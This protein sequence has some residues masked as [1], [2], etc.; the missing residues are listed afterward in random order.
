LLLQ[1]LRVQARGLPLLRNLPVLGKLFGSEDYLNERSELVAILL[2]ASAPPP[3]PFDRLSGR[4]PARQTP[5]GPVPPPRR[6]ISPEEERW[7]RESPEWPWNA[8]R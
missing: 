6:W 1:G 3:S 5:R 8:L 2:P 4:K 7:L